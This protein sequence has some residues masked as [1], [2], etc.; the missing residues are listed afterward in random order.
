[1]GFSVQLK[2]NLY[3]STSFYVILEASSLT[4]DVLNGSHNS[5]PV[6]LLGMGSGLCR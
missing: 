6:V 4:I 1:M 2:L 3:F 5:S